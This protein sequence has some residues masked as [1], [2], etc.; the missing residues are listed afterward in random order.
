MDHQPYTDRPVRIIRDERPLSEK[1]KD[2]EIEIK[3]SGNIII[4][5]KN[6]EPLVLRG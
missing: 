6:K 2:I 5:R 1:I 4:Y 3:K